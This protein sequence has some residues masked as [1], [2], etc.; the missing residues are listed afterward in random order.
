MNATALIAEDE[1]TIGRWL[2]ARLVERWPDLRIVA[3][4]ED[5]LAARESMFALQPDVCFVDIQ[6][7]GMTGI[8]VV[9]EMADEWPAGRPLPLVV[10][11]TAYPDFAVRAF[12]AD[13]V[14]Y[15]VK[16]V[17]PARLDV[18]VARLIDRLA[19]RRRDPAA[20]THQLDQLR[21]ALASV[22][23]ASTNHLQVLQLPV[24][25]STHFVPVDDVVYLESDDKYVR[26][27]TPTRDYHMRC[28]L[29]D[30]LP[31]LDPERFWRIH[32]RT[33][34]RLLDIAEARR[35]PT[36]RLEVTLRR[37][38]EVLAVSRL[39]ASRFKAA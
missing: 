27:V 6:L 38:P 26:V 9:E 1:P 3:H 5:G 17:D 37:R 34:V 28:P 20:L 39:Y 29:K 14:D 13:S 11:V 33:V 30:L 31:R 24:G 15:L 36:G 8:E 4:V 12:R 23:V 22:G 25:E 10:F 19:T 7:P 2:A 32:R 21:Q 35:D 18:C 16:P